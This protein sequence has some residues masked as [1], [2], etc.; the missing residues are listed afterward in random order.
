MSKYLGPDANGDPNDMTLD[1]LR[2]LLA[3]EL[4]ADAAFDGWSP[5]AL[6]AAAAR[7]RLKPEIAAL[8]FPK[9]AMDMIAAWFAHIDAIMAAHHSP[10]SLSAMKIRERITCLVETRLGLL[11]PHREALRRAQAVLA[12]PLNLPA[13]RLGWHAADVMWS[14][15]GDRST[16]YNHYTKRATLGSVYAATLLTFVNDNSEDWAETKAFLARRIENVMQFEKAKARITS[17]G[18]RHF[19]IARFLGRLRYPAT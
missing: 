17:G 14:A 1:E 13:V 19:S 6:A 5:R 10:E 16:D 4:P 9:G 15:A 8:V 12:M 7:L 3:A 18:D 2:P 11:A